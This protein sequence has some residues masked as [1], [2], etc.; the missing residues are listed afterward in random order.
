MFRDERW[1]AGRPAHGVILQFPGRKSKHKMNK[2]W[3]VKFVVLRPAL[4]YNFDVRP[5]SSVDRTGHS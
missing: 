4:M 3:L 5:G 1:I 2:V